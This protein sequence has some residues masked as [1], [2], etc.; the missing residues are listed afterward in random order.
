[1]LVLRQTKC[2]KKLLWI[3]DRYLNGP[4]GAFEMSTLLRVQSMQW[5]WLIAVVLRLLAAVPVL[6][7]PLVVE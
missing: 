4:M 6:L 7:I 1:M 3:Q 2:T 5:Q